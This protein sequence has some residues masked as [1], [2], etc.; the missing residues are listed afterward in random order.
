MGDVSVSTLCYRIQIEITWVL[1]ALE[2]LSQ[3]HTLLLHTQ[4][5]SESR[6]SYIHKVTSQIWPL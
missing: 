2:S 5:V 6:Q 1:S 4:M 3:L